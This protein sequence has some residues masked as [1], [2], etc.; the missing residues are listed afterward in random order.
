MCAAPTKLPLNPRPRSGTPPPSA[1]DYLS[2][3]DMTSV[4]DV[5]STSPERE[6][7]SA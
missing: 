5:D 4:V 7:S 6:R 3:D 2:T 1:L